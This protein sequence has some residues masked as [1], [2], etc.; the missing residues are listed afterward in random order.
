MC[1]ITGIINLN[2]EKVEEKIIK[3]MTDILAHRGPD[4]E[5]FYIKEN[6]G[7]GHRRLAIIDLSDEAKQPMCNENGKVWIVYNGEIY[8][9]IELAE[10]LKKKGHHFKS[11]SDT[12]VILH[13][14]EE[15]GY[16][17]LERFIGMF[18]FALWDSEKRILFCA[19]DRFGIKPFYY[20]FDG[21]R[22]IFGSEIKA[23]L[24]S[25]YVKKIPNEEIICDYLIYALKNHREGT[26]FS[27]IKTIKP[28]HY[29]ILENNKIKEERYWDINLE[30]KIKEKDE[31]LI[32]E[33]FLER[34]KNSVEIHLRSDVPVGTCL[35]GG[36]DS[37]AI[38]CLVDKLNKNPNMF[39]FSAVYG[40]FKY[41]EKKYIDI[42][43]KNTKLNG[44]FAYQNPEE[45]IEK[46]DEIIYYQEEPFSSKSIFAQ[47]KVMELAKE[48]GLKVLLDGQGADEILAGYHYYYFPFFLD[49]IK[50]FEIKKF[51][52]EFKYYLNFHNYSVIKTFLKILYYSL[53]NNIERK[54]YY[55]TKK[56]GFNFKYSKENKIKK[57]NFKSIF[58]YDLYLNLIVKL[59]ALLHYEDRNSMA[60][61]IEARVPFLDHRL[62]E[63][64]FSLPSDYKIKN[65]FTK[66]ILRGS[67]KGIMPD[68]ILMRKDKI[69]FFTPEYDWFRRSLK[70]W[71]FD[72]LKSDSMKKNNFLISDIIKKD[73][74]KV[75]SGKKKET[76]NIWRAINLEL[77]L[78][79][80]FS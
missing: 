75:L 16:K 79:K 51:F 57:N 18:A 64:L 36:L 14:Y 30:N 6:I 37:S 58:D 49:L 23:I 15:Y 66:A 55:L 1:G 56:N 76:S 12:E 80:F 24:E 70:D 40:D 2:D 63:F 3:K 7:L 10:E 38:V 26:F 67:L 39:S 32:R 29:L 48:K 13:S 9:Y 52:R 27:G 5:G 45:L 69:G 72:I 73:F 61:S 25:G 71:I 65:G 42:V 21:K 47:W 59:P 34:F 60:H 68:E 43:I 74:K 46:I 11:K 8:N 31:N 62:V 28:A 53:P 17:C 50:S 78:R 33:E 20:F 4:G 77:F 41:D 19:R 54:I 22:F 44:F 35:S